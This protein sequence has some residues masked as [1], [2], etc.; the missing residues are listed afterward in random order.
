[1]RIQLDAKDLIDVVENSKPV[2]ASQLDA[3]LRKRSGKLVYSLCNIRGLA[4]PI[5][6]SK[7]HLPRILE[8]LDQLE[9][10]PHCYI[11][12]DIDLMELTSAVRC[13]EAG[14]EYESI[15]PYVP[16]FDWVFPQFAKRARVNYPLRDIVHDMWKACP[17]ILGPHAKVHG[18]QKMAMSIDRERSQTQCPQPAEPPSEP[19]RE[20]LALKTSARPEQVAKIESW[21]A[22]SP[23]RCPALWMARAVGSS[24]SQNRGYAARRDDIFDLAATMAIPYVD[25]ITLDRTMLHYVSQAIRRLSRRA[26][27]MWH[28]ASVFR[29]LQELMTA[30]S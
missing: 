13:F 29:N 21:I 3:W 8:Y 1:M 30:S 20:F 19:L 9:R 24:M 23:L 14:K 25:R 16:R 6:A 26:P 15:D 28:T 5:A 18:V 11:R 10:L 12:T 17:E 2:A 22:A 27:A 4:G 7:S